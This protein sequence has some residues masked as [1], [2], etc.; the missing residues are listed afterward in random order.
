MY[1][2]E[3]TRNYRFSHSRTAILIRGHP[4]ISVP[5]GTDNSVVLQDF[6]VKQSFFL[7]KSFDR[8][9]NKIIIGNQTLTQGT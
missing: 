4:Y 6:L 1:N 3:E 9:Y 7:F 8:L 2:S 5:S